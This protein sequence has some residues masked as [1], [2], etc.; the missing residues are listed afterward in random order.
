M[1]TT[2]SLFSYLSGWKSLTAV[3]AS[4][5]MI[6]RYVLHIVRTFA[7]AAVSD[8]FLVSARVT[9]SLEV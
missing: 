9:W 5:N 3:R 6:F 7:A 1:L 8:L 4:S 2:V